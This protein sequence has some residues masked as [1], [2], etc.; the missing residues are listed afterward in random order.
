[1][2]QGIAQSE[3]SYHILKVGGKA[4]TNTSSP[5]VYWR[6]QPNESAHLE[7][8]QRNP[9]TLETETRYPNQLRE[10]ADPCKF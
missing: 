7:L 3:H 10:S 1:M 4:A 9:D 2:V 6:K 5:G 8:C